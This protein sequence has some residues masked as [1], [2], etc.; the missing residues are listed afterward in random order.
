MF[1][2]N[3]MICGDEPRLLILGTFPSAESRLRREY[4]GNPR[5][6]FWRIIFDVF[7]V[8]FHAPDYKAK[9]RVL[10]ENRVALW[11]TVAS[12]ET[13]G[14]LDSAIQNPV[15][16]TGIP[17]FVR[18]N[19]IELLLFNGGN[20]FTFYQRGNGKPGAHVV[21][22]STSPA[23]ARMRYGEKLERWERALKGSA[24]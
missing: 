11:D 12:C 7:G 4:Y 2:A 3:P 9:K 24:P 20:A 16:N 6:Q 15:Y 14:S 1:Y 22:P 8:P 21:L 23:N 13:D 17:E 19:G 10:I 18:E 5:N